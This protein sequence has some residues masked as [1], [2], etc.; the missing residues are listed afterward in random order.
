MEDRSLLRL[1]SDVSL[2][3]EERDVKLAG[4]SHGVKYYWV[5]MISE[6]NERP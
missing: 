3:G 5:I 4:R 2:P 6:L 1:S